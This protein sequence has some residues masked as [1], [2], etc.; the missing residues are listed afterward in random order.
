MIEKIAIID[1]GQMGAGIAHVCALAGLN[2]IMTDISDAKLEHGI[3][4]ING[5]PR[6]PD[7][8]WQD[9]GVR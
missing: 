5:P 1:S 3:E 2:I 8:P 7:C 6:S 4:T 9:I